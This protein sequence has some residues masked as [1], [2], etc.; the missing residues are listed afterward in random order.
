[1]VL[2]TASRLI[3]ESLVWDNHGCM[4]LRHE[5]ETFLPQLVRY[6]NSG[7]DIVSLN[8]GFDALPWENTIHMI[9]QFRRWIG[10]HSDHY[11]LVQSVEDIQRARDSGRL[12]ICF[13]IEGG[14]SLNADAG[15]GYSDDDLRAIL[16]GN[17][18]RVAGAV[19][20]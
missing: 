19:W 4:P 5:D 17:H 8:V 15:Q 2:T 1:M 14:N 20:K 7:I 9:A 18:L 10:L 6:R 3:A 13:D 11:R 12:G 16:G